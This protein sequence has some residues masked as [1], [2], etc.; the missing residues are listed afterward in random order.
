MVEAM[1]T[2]ILD[3]SV[4]NCTVLAVTILPGWSGIINESEFL[5]YCIVPS[6]LR[7]RPNK[8]KPV[9]LKLSCKNPC[10][11]SI[12]RD[13]SHLPMKSVLFIMS[14]TAVRIAATG[15]AISPDVLLMVKVTST[16]Q[17]IGA[18]TSTSAA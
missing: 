18:L 4:K 3:I 8:S 13:P 17:G 10:T 7:M 11:A 15:G 1:L 5:R 14:T 16:K 6:G 2:V 9:T 12:M